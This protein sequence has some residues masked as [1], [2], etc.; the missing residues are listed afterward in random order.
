M[1]NKTKV[2]SDA[3]IFYRSNCYSDA[4]ATRN[5]KGELIEARSRCKPGHISLNYTEIMDIWEAL[6]WIK[7]KQLHDVQVE[8]QST[9]SEE[10]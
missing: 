1:K 6:S 2:N 5:Q 8:T 9:R 3:A 4:F 7:D 10:H